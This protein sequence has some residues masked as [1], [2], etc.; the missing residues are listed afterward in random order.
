[1]CDNITTDIVKVQANTTIHQKALN[2]HHIRSFSLFKFPNKLVIL[3]AY[4]VQCMYVI[5]LA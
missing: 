4:Y 5:A 1:M 3:L 2:L